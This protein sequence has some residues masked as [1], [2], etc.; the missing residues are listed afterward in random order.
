MT[1][2]PEGSSSWVALAYRRRPSWRQFQLWQFLV[3]NFKAAA[4][5]AAAVGG[6]KFLAA[7]EKL[8]LVASVASER[9][10]VF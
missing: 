6:G 5:A 7:G 2:L 4:A 3:K 10:Q 1:I 8:V 9:L